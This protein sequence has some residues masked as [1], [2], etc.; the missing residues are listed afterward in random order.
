MIDLP[1]TMRAAPT[2][3]IT[4]GTFKENIAGTATTW[5]SPA[6]GTMTPNEVAI[7]AGNTTTAGQAVMLQGGGGTGLI[8]ASADF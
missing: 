6:A 5:V 8:T 2:V 7:T 1:V 3:A 4:T